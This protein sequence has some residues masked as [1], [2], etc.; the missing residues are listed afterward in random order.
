MSKGDQGVG[1][2]G[3]I[4]P[5][6]TAQFLVKP[7]SPQLSP[8]LNKKKKRLR[9]EETP[10]LPAGRCQKS[11]ATSR[12]R[13][14]WEWEWTGRT[15][16]QQPVVA[17]PPVSPSARRVGPVYP[18]PCCRKWW[19]RGDDPQQSWARCPSKRATS[20]ICEESPHHL[21]GPRGAASPLGPAVFF[22]GGSELLVQSSG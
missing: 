16:I 6:G 10:R 21:I 8:F 1:V 4:F 9:A 5:K 7:V 12:R 22:G 3:E 18:L 11:R 20:E 14:G 19:V 2:R 17:L 13:G 15:G